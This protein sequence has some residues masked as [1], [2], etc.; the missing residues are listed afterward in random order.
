MKDR[1][2]NGEWSYYDRQGQPLRITTYDMG[3]LIN[4]ELIILN[5]EEKDQL[6]PMDKSSSNIKKQKRS[7]K[8]KSKSQT[9]SLRYLV[10][11]LDLPLS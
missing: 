4:D 3:K 9:T 5:K 1:K 7:K 8:S 6:N 2:R 10:L 11:R